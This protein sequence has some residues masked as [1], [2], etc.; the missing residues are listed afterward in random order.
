VRCEFIISP[1]LQ[2]TYVA[3]KG[4]YKVRWRLC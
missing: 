2:G 1:D 4:T 3:S